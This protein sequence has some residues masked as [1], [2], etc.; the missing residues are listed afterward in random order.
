MSELEISANTPT[1]TTT[2]KTSKTN[3]LAK[4]FELGKP[5]FKG[6]R[7]QNIAKF[8]RS[9][10]LAYPNVNEAD[11][12]RFIRKL[13]KV[14]KEL[15]ITQTNDG[16]LD[17]RYA[18]KEDQI[19]DEM[20]AVFANESKLN[21]KAISHAGSETYRGIF[22]LGDTT[23]TEM[24]KHNPATRPLGKTLEQQLDNLVD[25]FNYNHDIFGMP[26]GLRLNAK[27][28][29]TMIKYPKAWRYNETVGGK[30]SQDWWE[31]KNRVCQMKIADRD[32]LYAEDQR[33]QYRKAKNGGS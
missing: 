9:W 25:Y 20:L 16:K 33:K 26:D 15:K 4:N 32:H 2:S 28:M 8:A 3:D 23:F 6:T 30:K 12:K 19:V 10:K 11:L 7:E 21:P 24:K 14:C 17:P 27:R 5:T 22:Q 29:A 1:K 31:L 18:T 13:Y